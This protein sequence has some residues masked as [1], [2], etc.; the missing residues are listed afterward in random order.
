MTIP[1]TGEAPRGFDY[2]GDAIFCEIWTLCGVPAITI[3]TGWSANELP[4]KFQVIGSYGDDGHTLRVAHWH[5][6]ELKRSSSKSRG[7]G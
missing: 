7:N 4:P 1:A 6:T 5:E 2:T 3:L